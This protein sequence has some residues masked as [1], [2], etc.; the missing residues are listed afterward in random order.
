MN[1]TPN[2]PNNKSVL[3]A[4]PT[5]VG[6]TL[7]AAELAQRIGGEIVCADA[8][9]IYD[10]L[11]V[12]TAQPDSA[13]L[14]SVPH[15][16]FAILSLS[17]TCDVSRYLASA[18][19]AASQISSRGRIPVFC[20]GTGFY[21]KAYTHGL[22]P[23]PAPDPDFRRELSALTVS[24]LQARLHALD[25]QA[26]TSLDANNP[27]RLLRAIEIVVQTGLPL[28]ASRSRWN[29]VPSRPHFG[30]YLQRDRSDIQ[31]RITQNVTSLLASGAID[32]VKKALLAGIST[33]AEKAIGFREITAL[34]D[35]K[36]SREECLSQILTSTLRYA[37]RQQTWFKA[38]PN[39]VPLFLK[40]EESPSSAIASIIKPLQR[41]LERSG[42]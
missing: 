27:R 40:P 42:V 28:S 29:E 7:F 23:I 38:Q 24:Q 1:A 12:L 9:Q 5:G 13:T 10:G 33:T 36:I 8:F 17:E 32:E 41:F 14:A 15:H 11:R 16:L 31:A 26:L 3:I 30:I 2:S 37:K 20:G 25:P 21:L 4:G 19:K 22:D 18:E 34:L 35:G 39:F 6:K